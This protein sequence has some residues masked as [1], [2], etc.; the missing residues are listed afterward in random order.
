MIVFDLR[1]LMYQ[2]LPGDAMAAGFL[3]AATMWGF[4]AVY[5]MVIRWGRRA[6]LDSEP[7]PSAVLEDLEP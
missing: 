2:A 3:W 6:A 1:A 7:S 4:L 5:R